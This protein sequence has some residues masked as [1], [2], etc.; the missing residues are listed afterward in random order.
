MTRPQSGA[1]TQSSALAQC[2]CQNTTG[3]TV[4]C[5]CDGQ[6]SERPVPPRSVSFT[7]ANQVLVHSYLILNLFQDVLNPHLL[8]K[9]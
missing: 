5:E 1:Q 3:L 2:R 7:V 9:K 4:V 6:L 8:K